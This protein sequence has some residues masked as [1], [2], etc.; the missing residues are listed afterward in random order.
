MQWSG[1]DSS[2]DVEDR[3]NE[4]G[5]NGGFGGGGI[6]GIH[7]GVGG[8]IIVA[9]LS[10]FFHRDFFQLF[11]GGSPVAVSPGIPDAARNQAE[12]P[13]VKFVSNAL[14]DI[15]QN[16]EQILPAQENRAYRHAKLVLYRDA[17]PSG[18]GAAQTATGP[19]YCPEDEKVY[20]DLGFFEELKTR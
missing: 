19:F 4:S 7:L 18:C 2:N 10:L 3:R 9:L 6:G 11:S 12:A 8:T 20:L 14:D 5:G 13:T 1:G 16:W 17:Y 15:Q